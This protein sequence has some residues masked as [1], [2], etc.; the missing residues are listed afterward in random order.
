MTPAEEAVQRYILLVTGWSL[1]RYDIDQLIKLVSAAAAEAEP[2]SPKHSS[3]R[4]AKSDRL[5]ASKTSLS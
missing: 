3:R 2:A 5:R 4:T 1:S